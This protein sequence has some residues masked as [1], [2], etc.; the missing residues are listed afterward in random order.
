MRPFFDGDDAKLTYRGYNDL[1]FDRDGC[2][3]H[4]LRLKNHRQR[5]WGRFLTGTMWNSPS[6]AKNARRR[7]ASY[8]IP[9]RGKSKSTTAPFE[10]EAA[11]F[12]KWK[13]FPRGRLQTHAREKNLNQTTAPFRGRWISKMKNTPSRPATNSRQRGKSKS[14]TA[15]FELEAAEFPKWK[16][17]PRGWQSCQNCRFESSRSAR[18]HAEDLYSNSRTIHSTYSTRITTFFYTSRCFFEVNLFW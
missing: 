15:P 5:E 18:M 14:T 2:E 13:T 16:T 3:T 8:T 12:P 4:L 10:F 17:F 11:D 9:Q 6:E 7:P 1:L